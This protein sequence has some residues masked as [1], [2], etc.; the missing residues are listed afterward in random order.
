MI[1]FR[2]PEPEFYRKINEPPNLFEEIRNLKEVSITL[3]IGFLLFIIMNPFLRIV[4]TTPG[5]G[6]ISCRLTGTGIPF[7]VVP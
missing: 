7:S 6:I 5:M 2:F 1:R 3:K 4:L